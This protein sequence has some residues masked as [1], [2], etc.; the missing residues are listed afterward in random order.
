MSQRNDRQR[1]GEVVSFT[2]RHSSKLCRLLLFSLVTLDAGG[3]NLQAADG[4]FRF[5]VHET[6]KR[7]SWYNWSVEHAEPPGPFHSESYNIVRSYCAD[8][9]LGLGN[10]PKVKTPGVSWIRFDS[11]KRPFRPK[12]STNEKNYDGGGNISQM[13]NSPVVYSKTEHSLTF[14]APPNKAIGLLASHPE[15]SLN[16]P[17]TGLSLGVQIPGGYCGGLAKQ[18]YHIDGTFLIKSKNPSIKTVRVRVRGQIDSQ[19]VR[20]SIEP[21]GWN[22]GN[23]KALILLIAPGAELRLTGD[24]DPGTLNQ[25]GVFPLLI[26]KNGRRISGTTVVEDIT[27]PVD[28]PIRWVFQGRVEARAAKARYPQKPIWAAIER[29]LLELTMLD[30][31]N[32]LTHSIPLGTKVPVLP[33]GPLKLTPPTGGTQPPTATSSTT[34][35]PLKLNIP[36]PVAPSTTTE[37]PPSSNPTPPTEGFNPIISLPPP[38]P[39]YF[40]DKPVRP[41]PT[42]SSNSPSA[43]TAP[44]SG[45]ASDSSSGGGT[46]FLPLR[47]PVPL[48]P[49]TIGGAAMT[50]GPVQSNPSGGRMIG[51]GVIPRG[52]D[53]EGG[54]DSPMEEAPMGKQEFSQ[55]IAGEPEPD[56]TAPVPESP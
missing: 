43:P 42:P 34:T 27:L 15:Q 5:E 6:L 20:T 21:A 41:T 39:V 10:H 45:N 29:Q 23:A 9:G 38:P 25:D 28:Q 56:K 30:G 11:E 44:A 37:Q 51:I 49:P 47:N 19:Y 4:N 2:H 32:S 16:Y 54:A 24:M 13:G 18:A 53:Q 14:L 36:A 35:S 55:E 7:A 1:N 48:R 40:G 3:G 17:N 26:S 31:G 12:G 8:L 50:P 52:I 22:N 33:G 46:T